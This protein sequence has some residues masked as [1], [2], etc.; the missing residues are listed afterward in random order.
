M[1]DLISAAGV[2]S[3]FSAL[4]LAAGEGQTSTVESILTELAARPAAPDEDLVRGRA[5]AALRRARFKGR[6]GTVAYLSGLML[7]PAGSAGGGDFPPDRFAADFSAHL[8][9][10]LSAGGGVPFEYGG[11]CYYF[12]PREA[13]RRRGVALSPEAAGGFSCVAGACGVVRGGDEAVILSGEVVLVFPPV[14][15]EGAG[16]HRVNTDGTRKDLLRAVTERYASVLTPCKADP[17][18]SNYCLCDITLIEVAPVGAA[19]ERT[20]KVVTDLG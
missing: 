8:E 12:C 10:L 5:A 6:H 19:S 11:G 17:S 16:P 14:P 9:A 7:E 3:L 18:A 20:Y 4:H 13:R 2:P 1:Q 15:K